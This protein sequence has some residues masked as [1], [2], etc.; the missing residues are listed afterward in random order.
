MR[1]RVA[2]AGGSLHA[3]RD[4]E[5]FTVRAS[6]PRDASTRVAAAEDDP[7]SVAAL[8]VIQAASMERLWSI[9]VASRR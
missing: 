4:G 8:A 3:G 7:P 2:A 6:L 9:A 5:S 1:Q